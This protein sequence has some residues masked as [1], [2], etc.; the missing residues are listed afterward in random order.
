ML[1]TEFSLSAPTFCKVGAERGVEAWA[2]SK[3]RMD[4]SF[5]RRWLNVLK[6]FTSTLGGGDKFRLAWMPNTTQ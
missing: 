6:T 1:L 5:T 2:C 3:L 4:G